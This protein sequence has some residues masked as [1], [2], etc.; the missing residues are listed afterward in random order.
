MNWGASEY[1]LWIWGALL[2]LVIMYGL[3]R[4]RIKTV[5]RAIPRRLWPRLIPGFSLRR[6]RLRMALRGL[7]FLLIVIAMMRPQW[8]YKM[9]ESSQRGL[10]IV[11]ALD[12]SKSMLATDLPPS[13]L[14]QSKWAL[15]EFTKQLNGDRIGLVAF[16]GSSFLQCPI[17]R[18]YAAFNMM[19]NDLYAGIIPRGGTNIGAAL[20]TAL[21]SFSAEG[22]GD[23]VIILLTDG[24]NHEGHAEQLVKKLKKANVR[25]YSVGVGTAA[26]QLIPLGNGQG[27]LKDSNGNVVKSSLNEKLLEKLARETGGFYVR[28]TAGDFGLDKIYDQGISGLQ[29]DEQESRMSKVYTERYGWFL[30]AA[31]L[32]LLAETGLSGIPAVALALLFLMPNSAEAR[33]WQKAYRANDFA[34][35]LKDLETELGKKNPALMHYDQ[36]VIQF[37][38]KNYPEAIKSF[39]SAKSTDDPALRAKAQYN[40]GTT[41]LASTVGDQSPPDQQLPRVEQAIEELESAVQADPADLEAKQNLER[42]VILQQKMKKQEEQQNQDQKDQDQKDKDQDQ[43]DQKDQNQQDQQGQDQQ[44]QDGKKGDE[45][46]QDQDGQ[47]DQQEQGDESDQEQEGQDGKQGDESDQEKD[48]KSSQAPRKLGE[49]T[50]G[51]AEQLMNSMRQAEKDQRKDLTP[52]LGQPVR[53]EKDW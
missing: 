40:L 3:L 36:G 20:E 21:D 8:G 39:E 7:A 29:R 45:S 14:Q 31:L 13:R 33:G 5:E 52:Y 6:V 23:R 34:Y 32:L 41:I 16:A 38:Q 11:I 43:K 27:Y 51:E 49:M 42:A 18:D 47:K 53:V 25:L 28:S 22:E 48:G 12:T 46:E 2:F 26:G 30:G 17:S 24:E 10:D 9:E 50:E 1:M 19:L 35:A 44:D 37:D 4:N 15:N